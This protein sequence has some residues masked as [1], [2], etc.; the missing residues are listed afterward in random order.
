[1]KT[2]ASLRRQIMDEALVRHPQAVVQN[3]IRLWRRL[4]PELIS[5]IG[6]RSF[7]PL[8]A[9]S[10]RLACMQYPWLA[11][12]AT[13]FAGSNER[14]AALEERLQAQDIMRAG[15]GSMALFNI[16][17]NELASLIGEGLTTH[18]LRLTSSQQTSAIPPED[19]PG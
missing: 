14:F 15:L 5:M 2:S 17:L 12:E 9:R 4:A 16:F 11:Q 1:M 13:T 19:F 3:T 6:E 10:V 18:L 7:N 8:Y